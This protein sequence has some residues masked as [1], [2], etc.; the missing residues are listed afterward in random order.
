MSSQ[1]DMKDKAEQ[2]GEVIKKLIPFK[3][4]DL[5]NDG[6]GT[7]GV[8]Y[9]KSDDSRLS[10]ARTP[11]SHTHGNLQNDG[12]VKVNSTVQKSKNI[13]TDSNGYLS[14]EDKPTIPTGSSTA[15]DI[16]MN[17]TQS[18]GSL[19]TFAKADHV[20]P[21]DT[22]RASTSVATTSS[23]GLM[24]SADKTKLDGVATNANNYSHPISK[25]CTHNHSLSEI[26]STT[27]VA[28]TITYTDNTTETINLVKYTGS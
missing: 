18:A 5:T 21:V 25:Q 9:V 1:Q 12:T 14:T 3:T 10:D 16:K 15:T 8:T 4:S 23:D 19:T 13:V 11:T 28:V 20:H 7:T 26:S 22:S 17:G 6:D 27:T 24:S 2:L